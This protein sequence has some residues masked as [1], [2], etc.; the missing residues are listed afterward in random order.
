MHAR[1]R[2]KCHKSAII[3]RRVGRVGSGHVGE[4]VIMAPTAFIFDDKR[5]NCMMSPTE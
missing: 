2:D 4:S 5:E 3:A 1:S